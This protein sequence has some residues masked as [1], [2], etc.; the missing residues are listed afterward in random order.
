MSVVSGHDFAHRASVLILS[1]N[2]F[3]SDLFFGHR[4]VFVKNSAL[5]LH[6][7]KCWIDILRW[8]LLVSCFPENSSLQWWCVWGFLCSLWCCSTLEV[9]LIHFSLWSSSDIIWICRILFSRPFRLS[10][11]VNILRHHSLVLNDRCI[12]LPRHWWSSRRGLWWKSLGLSSHTI[13]M[14]KN[15]WVIWIRFVFWNKTSSHLARSCDESHCVWILLKFHA[16]SIHF[17]AVD[18]VGWKWIPLPDRLVLRITKRVHYSSLRCLSFGGWWFN[19]FLH[20]LSS[21]FLHPW[22]RIHPCLRR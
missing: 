17:T 12:L 4:S 7:G 5:L 3:A 8:I 1:H 15:C 20:Y 19:I 22:W 2:L 16:I 9:K 21:S 11:A 18:V 13:I 6:I 14:R 10:W